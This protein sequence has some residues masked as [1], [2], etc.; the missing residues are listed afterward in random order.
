MDINE[1]LA[2]PDV[3]VT[4]E[5][6]IAEGA[7]VEMDAWGIATFRG[8]PVRTV[9][10]TL[11]W[12]LKNAFTLAATGG[13]ALTDQDLAETV[14]ELEEESSDPDNT[15]MVPYV[16][17][18]KAQDSFDGLTRLVSPWAVLGDL[19]QVFIEDAAD[20]AGEGEPLDGLYATPKVKAFQDRPV[21]LQ[22][23]KPGEWTAFFPED[24]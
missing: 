16:A 4:E 8:D 17:W 18:L 24:N 6:L 11:F 19:L 9:S 7:V 3:V 22:R 10:D 21:W 23:P 12:A 14:S 2:H 1:L 20:T 15:F 5:D 13:L